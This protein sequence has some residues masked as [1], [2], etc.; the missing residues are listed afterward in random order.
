M[1]WPLPCCVQANM[2]LMSSSG[3]LLRM[4]N[5]MMKAVGVL[6]G[7]AQGA[8]M[9]VPSI[10]PVLYRSELKGGSDTHPFLLSTFFI[11]KPD[12]NNP[13]A[14]A[15][16]LLSWV[17]LSTPHIAPDIHPGFGNQAT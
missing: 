8:A 3:L 1:H 6:S 15:E 10:C 7:V 4:N 9:A 11:P 16:A 12:L 14:V 5:G 13:Q 17:Q 2:K